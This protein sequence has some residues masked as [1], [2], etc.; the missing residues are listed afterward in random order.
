MAAKRVEKDKG[1]EE[2]ITTAPA[3]GEEP[4]VTGSCK[5]FYIAHDDQCATAGVAT[6]TGLSFDD[7]T[8]LAAVIPGSNA[9]EVALVALAVERLAAHSEC[10]ARVASILKGHEKVACGEC[11]EK[12]PR[13]CSPVTETVSFTGKESQIDIT[14]ETSALGE[15]FS[16][17]GGGAEPRFGLYR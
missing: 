8:L 12:G 2:K 5:F 1:Y 11:V 14:P 16:R 10:L 4:E 7:H 15:T 17:F 6:Q 9:V 3:Q 13:Q